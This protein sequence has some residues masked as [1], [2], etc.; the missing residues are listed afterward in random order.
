MHKIPLTCILF[1]CCNDHFSLS[2]FR[3]NVYRGLLSG[4]A[5]EELVPKR[6][7]GK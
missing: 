2:S 1:C 7:D 3:N 5:C 6:L 4:T